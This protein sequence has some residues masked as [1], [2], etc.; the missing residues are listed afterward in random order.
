MHAFSFE[1]P[2]V[3]TLLGLYLLCQY[4]CRAKPQSLYL[5]HLAAFAFYIGAKSKSLRRL[6]HLFVVLLIVSAASPVL[7]AG[8]KTQQPGRDIVLALDLSS[9]MRYELQDTK[10]S[11]FDALQ[12]ITASFLKSRNSDRTG[13]VGFASRV[14]VICPV[15]Y[16]KK[17]A[18]DLFE[19]QKVGILGQKT[20]L[21]DGL[22]QA[23]SMLLGSESESKVA[24]LFTDGVDNASAISKDIITQTVQ[25]TPV[26]LYIVGF[27]VGS[28]A[29]LQDLAKT[30][31]GRFWQAENKQALQEVFARI[32]R[33]Q[34]SSVDAGF[35]RSY[36]YL[37]MYPL[38]GAL[39]ILGLYL[40]GQ[41]KRGGDV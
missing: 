17:I 2:W 27:Q 4:F 5:P 31:G 34:P 18:S 12:E 23:Y 32:N 14:A 30:A 33:L 38:F 11:R 24:I 39:I 19:R 40:Y 9:S 16:D 1:Y 7:D 15:T 21:R 41:N 37:Y 13:L 22:Y 20:A 6:Q 29:W 3:F 25:N 8:Y 35:Q 26:T 10:Q 36:R 28:D